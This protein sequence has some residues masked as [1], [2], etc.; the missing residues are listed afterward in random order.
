MT[1]R[2]VPAELKTKSE[3]LA[4]DHG[5]AIAL[6]LF[7]AAALADLPRFTAGKNKGR[8]KGSVCWTETSTAGYCVYVDG[9]VKA[10]KVVRAWIAEIPLAPEGAALS[11]MWLGRVQPPC[12]SRH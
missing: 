6:H 9:P 4:S 2:T 12:G 8:R 3:P 11:G 1:A 5:M 10:G 7:G